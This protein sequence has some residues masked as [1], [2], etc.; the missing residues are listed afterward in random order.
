M[1]L[2]NL[3][4]ATAVATGLGG[5]GFL[6]IPSTVLSFYGIDGSG[7]GTVLVARYLG[8]GG[9]GFAA[10]T[11][12]LR[13]A[14][15]PDDRRGLVL[16]LFIGWGVMLIVSFTGLG[17]SPNGWVE[18]V[19]AGLFTLGYGYFQFTT[20]APAPAPRPMPAAMNAP[21]APARAVPAP[22]KKPGARKGSSKRRR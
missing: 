18:T 5:L 19:V 8:A 17:L 7:A 11:W 14:G 20:P 3:L 1:N 6:I 21:A 2:R 12:L 9:V 16:S 10:L 4:I 13:D 22:A 15:D